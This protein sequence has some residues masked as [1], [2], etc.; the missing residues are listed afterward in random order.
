MLL[1]RSQQPEKITL[2]QDDR[3]GTGITGSGSDI[4]CKILKAPRIPE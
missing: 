2:K 1:N 3:G 4:S